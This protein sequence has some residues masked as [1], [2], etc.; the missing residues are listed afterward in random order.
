MMKNYEVSLKALGPLTQIPDSQKVFGSLM[1]ILCDK[2][3]PNTISDFAKSLMRAPNQLSISS[4][5]PS[6]FLPSP[7]AFLIDKVDSTDKTA[8]QKIKNIQY[9]PVDNT[10][11]LMSSCAEGLS[12]ANFSDVNY[13]EVK[14]VQQV[15]VGIDANY[16]DSPGLLSNPFSLPQITVNLFRHILNNAQ[17]TETVKE[18][19]SDYTFFIQVDEKAIINKLFD[20]APD[21]TINN[22]TLTLGKRSSVGFNL[23]AVTNVVEIDCVQYNDS[24]VYM[25]TGM[26][27][28]DNDSVWLKEDVVNPPPQWRKKYLSLEL[29]TSERRPFSMGVHWKEAEIRGN[30]L[31]FLAPGSIISLQKNSAPGKNI[32]VAIESRKE[33]DIIFGNS[34]LYPLKEL[35]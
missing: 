10:V 23:F 9:M 20:G 29:F 17:E 3:P 12:V 11:S 1:H 22:A 35:T 19:V 18:E 8:Y 26:L 21:N 4:V 27:L 7:R 28:P 34:Y 16:R 33:R 32:P 30:Y 2:F 24:T 6:G 31:S 5:F 25:N 13:V 15:R 14:P